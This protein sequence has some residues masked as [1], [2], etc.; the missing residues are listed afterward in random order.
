M[1]NNDTSRRT[2]FGFLG[3]FL[4][5]VPGLAV[6]GKA[7]GSGLPSGESPSL[8]RPA[9]IRVKER[10]LDMVIGGEVHRVHKIDMV[11]E[12]G[13]DRYGGMAV[14]VETPK[15]D[16]EID[17]HIYK[18]RRRVILPLFEFDSETNNVVGEEQYDAKTGGVL[19]GG[20]DCTPEGRLAE[21]IKAV[22]TN[23]FDIWPTVTTGIPVWITQNGSKFEYP[24]HAMAFL[25]FKVNLDDIHF[26]A[27]MRMMRV[28]IDR[29]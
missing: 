8:E 21:V 1:S 4:V 5:V 6:V 19:R 13:L 10:V 25:P 22:R 17:G 23:G 14:I 20:P 7:F 29:A 27:P 26:I 24:K 11:I 18:G 2:F 28:E 15:G 3:G 9:P 12:D 16:I